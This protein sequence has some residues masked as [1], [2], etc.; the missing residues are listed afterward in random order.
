ML[1][2][3]GVF[4]NYYHRR[5]SAIYFCLPSNL[6]LLDSIKGSRRVGKGEMVAPLDLVGFGRLA[7]V[8]LVSLG[9]GAAEV[10]SLDVSWVRVF[11]EPLRLVIH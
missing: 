3:K 2:P 9:P 5:H 7:S 4:A 10:S 11:R 6:P 1:L 8:G